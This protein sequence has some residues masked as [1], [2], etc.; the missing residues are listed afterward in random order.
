MIK[1]GIIGGTGITAGELIRIL[2]NHP[3]VE[4]DFVYSHSK[5]GQY[6]YET[7]TD[8]WGQISK[9]F[10][11]KINPEI[12]VVFLALGHGNSKTFLEKNKFS[13]Q[14][15][16]IDLSTDFRPKTESVWQ[17]KKFVYGL[18]ELF[19]KEIENASNI[20]NPGCF[21]TAIQLSLL[22]LAQQALLND[23][24]HIHAITGAT[25][26]GN[27]LLPTTAFNWRN[28]NISVYKAFQHQHLGE[29][30]EN[31]K[32]L[33]PDFEGEINFVPMRGDFSRGIFAS[34]YLK[35]DISEKELQNLYQDFYKNSL[36]VQVTNSPIH[37]KQVV[38]TNNAFINVTKYGNKIHITTAIDNLLKGASGQAVENMNLMMGF[39]Q[40]EGL[41][42]K[43][44]V[45]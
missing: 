40:N 21:A 10:V 44:V 37:L 14:T 3:L 29:I 1:V 45:F 39:N 5:A 30:N 35:S 19:K 6:I 8:L 43:P 4:I 42:L 23:D 24:V 16:I 31:L 34:V 22:P 12:S 11:D 38:N 36:F 33:Q 27:S 17:N 41:K 9:K 2:L 20:A 32:F 18:P 13:K 26:A 7:H 15:K 25:G 28:N